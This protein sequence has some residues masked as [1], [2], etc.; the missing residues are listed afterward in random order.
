MKARSSRR[1][2]ASGRSLCRG[3]RSAVTS[4]T[5]AAL[6]RVNMEI[7]SL[8]FTGKGQARWT[9]CWRTALNAWTGHLGDAAGAVADFLE[10]DLRREEVQAC[11]VPCVCE[12]FPAQLLQSSRRFR[13]RL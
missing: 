10:S 8:D 13:V 2:Y 1:S 5:K 3:A 6:K 9:M 4:P 7:M 12:C 11:R